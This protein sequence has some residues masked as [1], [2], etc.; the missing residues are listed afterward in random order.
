MHPACG[1]DA[2]RGSPI[3]ALY[4]LIEY[5]AGSHFVINNPEENRWSDCWW[6]PFFLY[7][8]YHLYLFP[9]FSK[10]DCGII[11]LS[12][13]TQKEAN[14]HLLQLGM[15]SNFPSRLLFFIKWNDTSYNYSV[16]L[17]GFFKSIP[18]KNACSTQ[19]YFHFF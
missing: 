6:S 1:L 18:T 11:F 13:S 3:P 8:N 15:T 5:R 19:F 9:S 7:K 4:F 12:F 14:L 17:I 10:S 16:I 2:W